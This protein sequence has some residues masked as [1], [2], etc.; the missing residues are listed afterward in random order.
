M[1]ETIE[2]MLDVL[3]KKGTHI[4]TGYTG[5]ITQISFHLGGHV[6]VGLQ[7]SGFDTNGFPCNL[8]WADTTVVEIE[9]EDNKLGFYCKSKNFS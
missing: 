6:Q 8:Y 7:G 2:A 3:G 5:M 4:P 9:N 1:K